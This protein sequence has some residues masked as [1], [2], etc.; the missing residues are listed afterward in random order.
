VTYGGDTRFKHGDTLR[1]YGR[2]TRSVAYGSSTVP[3]VEAHFIQL[4]PAPRR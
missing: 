4:G 1:A 3:E 2:V